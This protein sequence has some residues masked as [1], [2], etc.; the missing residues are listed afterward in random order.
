VEQTLE[1][2]KFMKRTDVDSRR[3]ETLFSGLVNKTEADENIP[4]NQ[5]RMTAFKPSFRRIAELHVA[6]HKNTEIARILYVTDVTVKNVLQNPLII[7]HIEY[8]E[9]VKDRGFQSVIERQVVAAVK[10]QDILEDMMEDTEM[11][12]KLRKDI[13]INMLDRVQGKPHQTVHQKSE[14][15]ICTVDTVNEVK[16]RVNKIKQELKVSGLLAEAEYE[17]VKNAD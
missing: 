8:L 16:N 3:V 13:A 7:R 10:A 14:R 6:G 9:S 17:E 5:Y 2:H 1:G 4:L 11:D 15:V 12:A